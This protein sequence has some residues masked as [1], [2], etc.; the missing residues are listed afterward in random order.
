MSDIIVKQLAQIVGTPVDLMLQQLQ[1]AG[2]PASSPDD[3]ITDEQKLKL[4]EF[5]RQGQQSQAAVKPTLSVKRRSVSERKITGVQGKK[6][7]VTVEV[8]RKKRAAQRADT[9]QQATDHPTTAPADSNRSQE[10]TKKLEAESNALRQVKEQNDLAAKEKLIAAE[11][12]EETPVNE[13]T[14]EIVETVEIAETVETVAVTPPIPTENMQKTEETPAAKAEESKPKPSTEKPKTPAAAATPEATKPPTA[15][16]AKTPAAPAEP[17]KRRVG[18]IN[19][20]E[21][22]RKRKAEASAAAKQE[23]ATLLKKRPSRKPKPKV[24]TPAATSTPTKAAT[25]T[26]A[27]ANK[28]ADAAAKNKKKKPFQG[29][30]GGS[31]LHMAGGDSRRRKKKGGRR[32]QHVN[33]ERSTKHG[34]EKPVAPVSKEIEIPDTI[35]LSDLA[36]KL[37]V[38]STEII[39]RLMSL[40]V[41]ATINQSLD[42]D[43]AI[44]VTEE[45]GHKG[46]PMAAIEED[47]AALADTVLDIHAGDFEEFS[48]PPVVTIM[49]HVDHGKTSLLDYIR[50]SRVTAGEA[51]GITQHIGAYHVE[52]ENG[53]VSFLDTPGH[54]AFSSMRARGAQATD[55]V[56]VVVAADDSVM[57]QTREA[58]KHTRAAG[59]PLIVAI[60][61]MDK[62]NADPERVKSDLSALEVIPEEWGGDDVFVEVSAI[63]GQGVDNLL[64]SILLVSEIQEL[65]ARQEGPATGTVVE[66]SIEKGRGA[67][68]TVLVQEGTLKQGDMVLCGQQYGRVR[69]MLDE[70][71]KPTKVAGPSIPVSILGLSGVPSAGDDMIVLPNERKARE[72]AEIRRHRE[73]ETRLS[74]QQ[75]A[76][77]EALFSHM[78]NGEVSKVN[79]L[80]KAD[81]QGSVEALTESLNK[82]STDEVKVNIV[83]AGV[84]GINEGD[85]NLAQAANAVMIAFN[86]RAD[87]AAK[88]IAS[89]SGVDIRYYSIIYETID[90]V[91]A[92]MNGLLKPELREEFLGIAEVKDVF[93]STAMGP[94]AGC[95][96]VDGVVKRGLP[97]RVLRNNVVVYEGEL[98]SLRRH[99]DDVNEVRTGTECGIAV[100][101]YNDVQPG[102]QIECFQRTEIARTI[103]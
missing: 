74:A 2:I 45:L 99:K 91:K 58:I 27:N 98:E 95:L 54:A 15:V 61:K 76:K 81:V 93:R 19:F 51:G 86:V 13:T 6:N 28:P 53:I 40:G 3:S 20:F 5:I 102:D 103:D 12:A 83:L 25:P 62:E 24:A 37:S 29:R 36:M 49:G 43:T 89:E 32:Q 33:I 79:L 71:G 38:Q 35:V 17:P 48:R 64:E 84:G 21:E 16:K 4:L 31:K 85:V 66:A 78:E 97:I 39:K 96:I 73:R 30:D 72:V 67:V 55:I 82:L 100:K 18:D 70:L 59:V 41:M 101:N 68:A 65:K 26:T 87:A 47:D 14:E 60:N 23:A 11:K 9:P 57:P 90:D 7:T 77:L 94:V 52:T 10:L 44:L 8:R 75:A 42:Q 1:Q 69:A 50:S 22:A 63:T 92:A 88:R 80:V 56:I 46:I 34:F